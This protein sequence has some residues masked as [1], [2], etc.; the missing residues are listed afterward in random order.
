MPMH[1]DQ[2]DVS[3]RTVRRLV[4]EQFPRFSELPI[5]EVVTGGTVNAIFRIGE[6]YAARLP[7]RADDPSRVRALLVAEAAAAREFAHVSTVPAPEPVAL[8]QPGHGYGLPW[9]LQTWG[10]GGVAAVEDPAG[11]RD[12]ADDLGALIA[13]LRRADTQ[14]RRFAGE[15]RGGHLRDHDQWMD[16]CFERS[17]GLLDVRRLQTLWAELRTLPEVDPDAMCHG[18][19]TPSN[20]LVLDGHLA[21]V[22]DTGGF[23][24]AD[25]ALDLVAAWHL[26]DSER[27]GMLRAA[28]GCSEVQWRRGMAWALQQS[29]GL[30][31]YYADSNPTVSRWGR[32]T[33]HRLVN[34]GSNQKS[35]DPGM[36]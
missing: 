3:A 24:P 10:H 31:W 11:S 26:L 13:Q 21:G 22:L 1:D 17:E 23:V 36:G 2:L 28:L 18:D 6:D 9:S 14:G 15:G 25:P 4:D 20:I 35:C 8:G 7:L 27:R 33:L 16:V 5:R 12:F 34:E 32:R 19:L 29:M 30:V